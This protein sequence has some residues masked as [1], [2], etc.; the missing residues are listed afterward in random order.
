M[1]LIFISESTKYAHNPKVTILARRVT[2]NESPTTQT[3][4]ASLA[5]AAQL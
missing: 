1:T 5:S 3:L 4:T 2:A